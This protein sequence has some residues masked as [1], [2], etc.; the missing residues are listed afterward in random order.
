MIEDSILGLLPL[1]LLPFATIGDLPG[2]QKNEIGL[3][4]YDGATNTE[5]FGPRVGSTVFQPIMKCVAR[6]SSYEVAKEWIESIKNALHRYSDSGEGLEGEILSILM[7]GSPMY[8]GR[9]EQKFHEFQ[10]T[11]NIQVKE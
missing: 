10:V 11:F 2:T 8:L 7:V 3:I 1:E 5:Y 9:N 4:F 6:N